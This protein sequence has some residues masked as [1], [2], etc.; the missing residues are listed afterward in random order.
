MAAKPYTT[1]LQAGLGLVAETRALLELWSPGMAVKQ[2]CEAA[3]ES[4]RFPAVTARRLRNI[5][6]E[7]FAPRYLANNG[8]PAEHLKLLSSALPAAAMTQL[9]LLYTC[10]ANSILGDFVREVYWVRYASGYDQITSED[11]HG[12]V[13]RGI[14]DGRTVKRWSDSTTKR[15]SGY[16]TGCCADY[17]LL[18]QG[19][20]SNRKIRSF[21]ASHAVVAYLAYDIHFSGAGD[22][23]LLTHPDWALF[24]M[25][26]DDVLDELKQL[27]R[28]DFL[29]VQT[30]GDAVRCTW[31]YS[32][33]EALCDVL[34]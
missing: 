25:S 14:D 19:R 17:G 15:V 20:R 18:E 34:S 32:T 7:C 4:G 30:A 23:A 1:Q 16:L 29:M 21:R 3:L 31:K 33:M 2:L 12:F 26:R 5:V 8:N 10:R 13:Q 9:M 11:A 24:G 28:R 22:N 6:A 27:S